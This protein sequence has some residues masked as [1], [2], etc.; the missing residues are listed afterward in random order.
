MRSED[1]GKQKKVII[2]LVIII[3]LFFLLGLIFNGHSSGKSSKKPTKT[4]TSS[5]KVAVQN[6]QTANNSEQANKVGGI[7]GTI[8]I[9]QLYPFI[10][11]KASVASSTMANGTLPA[12]SNG[13]NGLPAIPNYQ[14]TP[15]VGSIPLPSIPSAPTMAASSMMPPGSLNGMKQNAV[16][17]VLTSD[18]GKN[19]AIMSDGKVV[20]EGDTYGGERISYITGDGVHFDNGNDISYGVK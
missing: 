15:N 20:Q 4:V 11:P 17:G 19:M 6:K 1:E 7:K 14:P 12:A 18:S 13:S 5:E 9:A 3:A 10:D 16:Q 8:D 2:F